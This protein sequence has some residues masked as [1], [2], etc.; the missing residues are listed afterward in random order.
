[1]NAQ[2]GSYDWRDRK[3]R[4]WL[5]LLLRYSVTRESRDRAAALAMAD[6]LDALGLRWRPASPKFFQKTSNAVC[7]AISAPNE[8]ES[9]VRLRK[10][11][12][13]IDEPRLRR[14]FQAAVGLDPEASRQFSHGR[15]F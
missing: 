5:L 10:H 4:E 2:F 11:I 3:L 12:A 13:R 6:E 14:A 15:L 1:M 7:D 8:G 9:I